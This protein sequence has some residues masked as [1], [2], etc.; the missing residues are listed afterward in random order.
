MFNQQSAHAHQIAFQAIRVR[1]GN[2]DSLLSSICIL[3]S[4]MV[5]PTPFSAQYKRTCQALSAT[6]EPDAMGKIDQVTEERSRTSGSHVSAVYPGCP[7]A[8]SALA[9][10]DGDK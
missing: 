3:V 7:C 10:L 9:R 6:Y 8:T 1:G 4:Q 5:A 2:N